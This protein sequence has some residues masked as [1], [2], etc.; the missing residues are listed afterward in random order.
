MLA[1]HRIVILLQSRAELGPRQRAGA[2]GVEL[3]ENVSSRD[4]ERLE[5]IGNVVVA[6]Y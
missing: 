4:D 3:L 5:L 2:V 1:T 6:R